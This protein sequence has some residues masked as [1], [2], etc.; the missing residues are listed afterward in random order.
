MLIQ[1]RC[2]KRKNQTYYHFIMKTIVCSFSAG[3]G[4]EAR[5]GETSNDDDDDDL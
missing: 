5:A 1:K 3:D 4:D 2:A